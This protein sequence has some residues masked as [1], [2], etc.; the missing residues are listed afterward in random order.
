M[1]FA[2]TGNTI[3]FYYYDSRYGDNST[4]D[5]LTVQIFSVPSDDGG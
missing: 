3:A 1:L 5:K 4:T 2:G